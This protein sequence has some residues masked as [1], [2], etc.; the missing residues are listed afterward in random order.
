MINYAFTKVNKYNFNIILHS[1]Y[2]KL[3]IKCNNSYV[4]CIKRESFM[5]SKVNLNKIKETHQKPEIFTTTALPP[6]DRL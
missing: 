3:D 1:S 4:T 5:Y 6:S 2:I